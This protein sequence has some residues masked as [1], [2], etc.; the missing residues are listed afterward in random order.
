MN[1]NEIL[2]LIEGIFSYEDA[3][4]I[5]SHFFSSKI[6]Y[7]QIKN[8]SSNERFGKDDEISKER[9][10]ALERDLE[11]LKKILNQAKIDNKKF[12]IHSSINIELVKP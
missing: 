12:K 4:E 5:L 6:K 7:H 10:P 1:D 11:K 9:I 8:W 3:D 2:T